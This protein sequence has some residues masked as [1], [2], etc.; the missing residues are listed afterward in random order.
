[1]QRTKSIAAILI[2]FA[3]TSILSCTSEPTID[4]G[5]VGASDEESMEGMGE[6]ETSAMT[7]ESSRGSREMVSRINQPTAM[8]TILGAGMRNE[9]WIVFE[10]PIIENPVGEVRKI[11]LWVDSGGKGMNWS[12]AG[13][14]NPGQTIRWDAPQVAGSGKG[15]CYGFIF[16]ALER[17]S[18]EGDLRPS[19]SDPEKGTPPDKIYYFDWTAPQVTLHS[20]RSIVDPV[21]HGKMLVEWESS[22]EWIVEAPVT[23][24]VSRDGGR[25][26]EV[27]R[28]GLTP[29]GSMEYTPPQGVYPDFRIRLQS[30]DMFGNIGTA[31]SGPLHIGGIAMQVP[32]QGN[33]NIEGFRV[34]FANRPNMLVFRRNIP[35]YYHVVN[36]T[37]KPIE[38]IEIYYTFDDE[39]WYLYGLDNDIRDLEDGG[40]E[41]EYPVVVTIEASHMQL[42]ESGKEYVGFH[43]VGVL[44]DGTSSTAKPSSSSSIKSGIWVEIDGHA[45][46]VSLRS[47][48]GDEQFIAG[49][50]LYV[51]WW[52]SDANLDEGPVTVEYSVGG[53]G[54]DQSLM[55]SNW[56][57][58]ASSQPSSGTFVWQLPDNAMSQVRV[59]VT[60]RDE[61]GN[62]STDMSREFSIVDRAELVRVRNYESDQI[63]NARETA[64]RHYRSATVFI[65][66][67]DLERAEWDLRQAIQ[68]WPS[69]S[70]ALNN[71]GVV[72][73]QRGRFESSIDYFLRAIETDAD[74]PEYYYNLGLAYRAHGEESLAQTSFHRAHQRRPT[75]PRPMVQ[76]AR[77]L[78]YQ[79]EYTSARQWLTRIKDLPGE[80][81][82]SAWADIELQKLEPVRDR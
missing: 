40:P 76:I 54:E 57:Q 26:Y 73:Y 34:E 25:N 17:S 21:G 27:V 51:E 50:R 42:K 22:D 38:F 66:T 20:P 11:R 67:G 71:L 3:V 43:I 58:L 35:L 30:V 53:I 31:T 77:S 49:Q 62:V 72:L 4:A 70:E 39:T 44:S 23:I 56:I 29:N 65:Q 32:S 68:L 80:P 16:Q 10:Q 1:M 2:I 5:M 61:V 64:R 7:D 47:P 60:C 75:D 52:A 36:T 14:Y 69:F 24:E 81:E 79:G 78:M 48:R 74:N 13:E 8:S 46:Y 15:D 41:K 19:R 18:V 33:R 9:P 55:E 12:I 82:W 59:R 45:P 28:T 37:G 6:N 63:E